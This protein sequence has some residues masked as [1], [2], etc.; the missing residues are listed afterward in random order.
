[1]VEPSV[2]LPSGWG[3]G[4]AL[5][6]ASR[7]G[8][9]AR[10][11][12]VPLETLVDSPM[13]AG[14]YFKQYDLDP[15]ARYPVRLNVVADTA[16]ELEA[17]AKVIDKHKALVHQA[18]KL[19]GVRNFDRYEF[20]VAITD[21]LGDI[22]L[23]HHRSSENAVGT[24][25]FTEFDKAVGD[26]GLLPH[27]Y[28]HSWN[29]KYRRPAD[30]WTPTYNVPM[31]GALLWVYEGLTS[32]WGDVL[33]ARAGMSSRQETLDS[34]ALT[35]AQYENQVGRRWRQLEDTTFDPILARRSPQPWRG[36]QRA[37]DYY[38]EGLLIWLDA[39]TLIREKSGGKKS[40]DD[41]GRLFFAGKDGQFVPN[42]YTF[43]DVVTALNT[44]QPHDWATFLTTRVK[45]V[46]PRA[47]LD[48][49]VRGGWKLVYA[50]TPSDYART[51]EG[52]SR[53]TGLTY[54]LGLSLSRDADVVGVLWD[55]PAFKAG[56]TVSSRVLA[57]NGIAY[58]ADRIKAAITEGKS[59]KPIEL[60][61]KNG[62][63]FRTVSINYT[64]GLR[65]PK[66]ERIEGTP[67]LLTR[68][69]EARK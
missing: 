31:R 3:Y 5:D 57:V 32:Y 56:I 24:G 1:M 33:A 39:D 11:K 21:R 29:G 68:I 4:V 44:I 18:D 50:D 9:V 13:F 61:I 22:G 19:F 43:D 46:A 40:L 52:A 41:F 27:E 64:G 67:D 34:I 12:P 66:L 49:L 30:L 42:P 15:G 8:D 47:P 36:W 20:L 25:Y 28:T 23:E 2:K 58:S 54:S 60:L 38:Q 26:R 55:G 53:S 51:I 69:H 48:G 16:A 7:E 45:D 17:D 14:R 65:Y 63:H 10:F 6:T 35:A 59:G 62:D 37:E